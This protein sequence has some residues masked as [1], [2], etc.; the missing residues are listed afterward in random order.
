MINL[1][2][3]AIKLRPIYL[4]R[5]PSL[6][7]GTLFM[8]LIL[9]YLFY[10]NYTVEERN[11]F[12]NAKDEE[13]LLKNE[14]INKYQIAQNIHLYQEQMPDLE[15]LESAVIEQFPKND[16][17]PNL[18]IQINQLAENS[19]IAVNDLLPNHEETIVTLK[20]KAGGISKIWSKKFMM[21]AKGT[22][23]DFINFVYAIAK[24]PRVMKLGDL[25]INQIHDDIISI[26]LSITIFYT[27]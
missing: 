23:L 8:M 10:S 3:K 13:Q 25:Q 2:L 24:V 18:L 1:K 14:L 11:K 27:N 17:I 16:D 6:L 26:K 15:K 21:N 20:G 19:K 9:S 4:W 12:N 7:V 22:Y 5:L